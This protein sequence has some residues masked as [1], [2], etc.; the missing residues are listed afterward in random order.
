MHPLQ[1]VLTTQIVS[2]LGALGYM[3]GPMGIGASNARRNRHTL[4]ILTHFLRILTNVSNVGYFVDLASFERTISKIKI[5]KC[6]AINQKHRQPNHG[7]PPRPATKIPPSRV[8]KVQT[9]QNTS[10][11]HGKQSFLHK[12]RA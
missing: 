10:H 7:Q 9:L 6:V 1:Y 11:V 3:F 5:Q 4:F 8:T 12:I 2:G